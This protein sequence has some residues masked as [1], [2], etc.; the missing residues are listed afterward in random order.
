MSDSVQR[1]VR[2]G[3]RPI[4][5]YARPKGKPSSLAFVVVIITG[6]MGGGIAIIVQ[7]WWLFWLSVGVILLGLPGSW[8]VRVMREAAVTEEQ[9]DDSPRPRHLLHDAEASGI[10]RLPARPTSADSESLLI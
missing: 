7:S 5:G 10:T 1:A 4:G 9:L 3:E 2:S 8:L 6:F